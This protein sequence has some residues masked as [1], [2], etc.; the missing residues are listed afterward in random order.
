M[1]KSNACVRIWRR[2]RYCRV[3]ATHTF[4]Q[5]FSIVARSSLL[6][7]GKGTPPARRSPLDEDDPAEKKK[8]PP[9]RSEHTDAGNYTANAILQY[10]ANI[11]LE[12]KDLEILRKKSLAI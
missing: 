9:N 5:S 8:K 3:L 10:K 11:V 4:R 12:C 1:S 2:L 6:N 7:P